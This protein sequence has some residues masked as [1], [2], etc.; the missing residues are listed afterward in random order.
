MRNLLS[1]SNMLSKPWKK[2]HCKYKDVLRFSMVGG[3]G[4][5][6]IKYLVGFEDS[7]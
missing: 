4:G 6:V 5:G 3:G 2:L 7:I 1:N